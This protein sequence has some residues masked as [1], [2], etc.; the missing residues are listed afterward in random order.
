MIDAHVHL[1]SANTANDECWKHAGISVREAKGLP[2]YLKQR[3]TGKLHLGLAYTPEN[4]YTRMKDVLEAKVAAGEK[5]VCTCID[6]SPDIGLVALEAGLRLREEF[7][8]QLELN[9]GAYPP[10]GFKELGSE[11]CDITWEAAKRAQFLVGLP[12]RDSGPDHP[13]GFD[14]HLKLL[15]EIA[16]SNHHQIHVHVDQANDPRENGTETLV[17]AVRWYGSPQVEGISGPTVWAV[18]MI[19]PSAYDDAKF[20]RLVDN[21]LKYNI[22]V[23]VCP[24]AAL[25]MRQLRPIIAPIHN[26]IARVRELLVAGVQVLLG[27]DNL[28]DIFVDF[29]RVDL[30]RELEL[31]GSAVRFYDDEIWGKVARGETLDDVDIEFLRRSLDEDQRVFDAI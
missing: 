14:G 24:H 11:R 16:H 22:G 30:A 17:E 13:I 20:Y 26:C 10:F 31:I 21:L 29:G 23:I 28:K 2:L 1:G 19:S 27:T 7:A 18:H 6:V 4:L 3:A 12:E 9:L 15:F 25:S 5:V 8:G